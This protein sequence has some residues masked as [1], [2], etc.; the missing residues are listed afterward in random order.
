[1]FCCQDAEACGHN[2][3]QC[4]EN[5]STFSSGMVGDVGSPCEDNTECG[6]GTYCCLA[7]NEPEGCDFS[8]NLS[9]TCLVL[10]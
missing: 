8:Q 6:S 1:M 3:D 5:C 4:V 10:P 2:L 7:D 9:C